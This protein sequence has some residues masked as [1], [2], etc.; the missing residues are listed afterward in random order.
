MPTWLIFMMIV[1]AAIALSLDLRRNSAEELTGTA[2][3][4][5]GAKATPTQPIRPNV[6]D[7]LENGHRGAVPR[8]LNVRRSGQDV[9]KHH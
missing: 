3:K 5:E 7:V 6:R 8:P 1:L 4:D 2:G 9:R